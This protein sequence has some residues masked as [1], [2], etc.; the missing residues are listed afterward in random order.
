MTVLWC[1]TVHDCVVVC[2]SMLWCVAGHIQVAQV[3]DR[4]EPDLNGEVNYR[5]IFKLLEDMGY[6]GFIGLEY[7]PR[8]KSCLQ[9][10]CSQP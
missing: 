5:Y 8:S 7:K 2:D 3:P 1:V 9:Y 10:C 4:G 6:D